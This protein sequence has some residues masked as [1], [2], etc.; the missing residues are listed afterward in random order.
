M[1][2]QVDFQQTPQADS[3]EL[4]TV[5]D[6][7]NKHIYDL[8]V[9]LNDYNKSR[10]DQAKIIQCGR[11]RKVDGSPKSGIYL[12]C[13]NIEDGLELL[14]LQKEALL[15]LK[16]EYNVKLEVK[17]HELLDTGLTETTLTSK[18]ILLTKL[19]S[20]GLT[21]SMVQRLRAKLKKDITAIEEEIYIL[22]TVISAVYDECDKDDKD[23]LSVKESFKNL[24]EYRNVFR[25]Q[26]S[27]LR[28]L[29]ADAK[30][31]GAL[32]KLKLP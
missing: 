12:Y 1:N 30:V 21:T 13:Q 2:Y 15:K 10:E 31:L 17:K 7:V 26:E 9:D 29:R 16:A 27:K 20:A 19:Q 24:N 8:S 28:K 23:D 11:L 18:E 6:K 22:R 14:D 4:R 3:V 5:I 32:I 25:K